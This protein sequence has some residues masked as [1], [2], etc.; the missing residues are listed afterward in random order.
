MGRTARRRRSRSAPA[1]SPSARSRSWPWHPRSCSRRSSGRRSPGTRAV[2]GHSTVVSAAISSSSGYE[3]T[4][5]ISASLG[6]NT[7]AAE[8]TPTNGT[9]RM[10]ETNVC[11]GSSAPSTSTSSGASP[12]SS[13]VS[14]SA[15]AER[16]TSSSCVRPPGNEISPGCRDRCSVRLVSTSRSPSTSGS[17]T[18][19]SRSPSPGIG[20][21][22]GSRLPS[23]RARRRSGTFAAMVE[24]AA[25]RAAVDEVDPDEVLR[26]ARRLITTPSENPAGPR[27]TSPRS[28]W[29]LEDLD[30]SPGSSAARRAGRA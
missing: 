8:T 21:G 19:A 4:S 3:S 28:P 17:S 26:F 15:V 30:G 10:A 6:V 2:R 16:S 9:M 22:C 23:R 14:R 18:A 24:E 1:R 12:S 25:V 5:A 7:G 27:T 11:T 29:I 20:A 13:C